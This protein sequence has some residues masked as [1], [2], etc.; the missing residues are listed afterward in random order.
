M[1]VGNVFAAQDKR[2][3]L[4]LVRLGQAPGKKPFLEVHNPTD[5]PIRTVVSSPPH[6]PVF[7]G[8]RREVTVPSGSSIRLTALAP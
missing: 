7:G 3:R 5:A 1:W 4:T 6:A 2:L 8:F